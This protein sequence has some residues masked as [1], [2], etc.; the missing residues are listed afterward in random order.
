MNFYKLSHTITRVMYGIESY[1]GCQID[2]HNQNQFIIYRACTPYF[3]K[4]VQKEKNI[5]K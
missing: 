1:K 5:S 2:N 4:N 3:D